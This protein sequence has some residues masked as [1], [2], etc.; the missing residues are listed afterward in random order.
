ML[1]DSEMKLQQSFLKSDLEERGVQF[2]NCLRTSLESDQGPMVSTAASL[3]QYFE[4]V[5]TDERTRLPSGVNLKSPEP[6]LLASVGYHVGYSPTVSETLRRALLDHIMN[7]D[8]LPPIRD[9]IYMV[10]WGSP[11]SL[12]RL[13]KLQSVLARLADEKRGDPRFETAVRNWDDDAKYL[14]NRWGSL[15]LK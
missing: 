14:R 7:A 10:Q 1:S 9:E 4:K 3:M 12:K 2:R 5:W 6:G 11:R 13:N 15:L 8:V